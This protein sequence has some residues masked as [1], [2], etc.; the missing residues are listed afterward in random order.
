M[1][2]I[3]SFQNVSIIFGRKPEQALPLVD[4]G[5]SRSEIR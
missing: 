5:K 3:V 2:P 1:S 4:A